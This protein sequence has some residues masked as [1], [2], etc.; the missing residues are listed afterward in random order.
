MRIALAQICPKTGD[1]LG[2]LKI[3]ENYIVKAA[4]QEANLII[5]PEMALTGYGNSDRFFEI[6]EPIPGPS[7]EF[8]Q[9][10]AKKHDIYVVW[11]MPEEG[12]KGVLYNSAAFVGP[13]G[14]VGKWRKL[15]LPGHATDQT[16]PGA[17]P[18]RRFFRAGTKSPIFETEIGKIGLMICYDTFF[19]EIARLLTLKG[20]DILIILS[21][22]P[23]FEKDIF[24]PIIKVRAMENTIWLAYC[25]LAG[26]EGGLSYWGG[27]C[28]ISPGNPKTKV[29]GEPILSKAP[30]NIES[31]IIADIDYTLN[32][33]FRPFFPVLRDIPQKIYNELS[34]QSLSLG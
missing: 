11:G 26:E 23:S 18:D 9:K 25:N 30:Y 2:N 19:P 32:K 20:A 4:E 21:G 28:V 3:F 16:G 5:F 6:A 17:F 34:E 29:P 14:Y 12:L 33:K 27:S 13:N 8:I 10:L 24:E 1:T 22:S 15:T 31:L 7:T